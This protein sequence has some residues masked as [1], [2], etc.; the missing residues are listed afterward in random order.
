LFQALAQESG[1]GAPTNK[2]EQQGMKASNKVMKQQ[3]GCGK[4]YKKKARNKVE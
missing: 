2:V 4:R 3:W 1:E